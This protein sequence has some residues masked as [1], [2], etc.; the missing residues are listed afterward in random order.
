MNKKKKKVTALIISLAVYLILSV[1]SVFLVNAI[2]VGIIKTMN[3]GEDLLKYFYE[4]KYEGIFKTKFEDDESHGVRK[5]MLLLLAQEYV[6]DISEE[7]ESG[8]SV[9]V[10]HS[11]LYYDLNGEIMREGPIA[12]I[13]KYHSEN[14]EVQKTDVLLKNDVYGEIPLEY[15][16]TKEEYEFLSDW[17]KNYNNE[18]FN[19]VQISDF[20]RKDNFFYPTKINLFTS[21]DE[22]SQT[23]ELHGN[24]EISDDMD[25]YLD[26]EGFFMSFSESGLP[27]ANYG[28]EDCLALR[29]EVKKFVAS[30]GFKPEVKLYSIFGF[31]TYTEIIT[32]SHDDKNVVFSE[33]YVVTKDVKMYMIIVLSILTVIEIIVVLLIVLVGKRKEKRVLEADNEREGD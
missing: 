7:D 4:E 11:A 24:F 23:V 13:Y 10:V 16:M 19:G 1:S 17:A 5:T 2:I 28:N 22:F 27:Q 18:E 12:L 26:E 14:G 33:R 8:V 29:S 32:S 20:Y 6:D 3:P 15:V 31:G 30:H 21:E 25:I 9:G